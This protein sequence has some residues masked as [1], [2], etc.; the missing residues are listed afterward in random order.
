MDGALVLRLCDRHLF[1]LS[2]TA[3]CVLELCNGQ[4]TAAQVAEK[5]GADFKIP[6]CE[7]LT[8]TLELCAKLADQDIIETV[9]PNLND[10]EAFVMADSIRY[11]KNPDVVLRE[12]DED[13]AL[14]FNPDTN[15][16]QILNT[17]GLFIWI[18][19][20]GVHDFDE[21]VVAIQQKF[22]DDVPPAEEVTKDVREFIER[23]RAVGFIGTIEQRG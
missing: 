20:D 7:A 15:Q 22:E 10:K 4:N 3:K 8:D 2:P 6:T 14:L 1:D 9:N 12:E 11:I 18:Q 5:L 19:C 21:I 17:T 23:M 16:T 13:G